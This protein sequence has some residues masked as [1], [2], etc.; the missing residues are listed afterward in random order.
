[1]IGW[2][3]RHISPWHRLGWQADATP[4]DANTP[5]P[6]AAKVTMGATNRFLMISLPSRTTRSGRP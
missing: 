1:M 5:A 3:A 4:A 2:P 6:T